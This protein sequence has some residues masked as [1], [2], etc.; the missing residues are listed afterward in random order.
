[1]LRNKK[2]NKNET[3]H[4]IICPADGLSAAFLHLLARFDAY[5]IPM[6]YAGNMD[7]KGLEL[8]DRLFVKFGK[9]FIPWRYT[10]EDYSFI[11][12]DSFE[13]LQEEKKNMALHN[14]TLASLL[15]HMRKV[16]KTASSMPLVP[17][18]IED[19]NANARGAVRGE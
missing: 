17:K 12:A 1:M 4:T 9:N 14:E 10:P 3:R 13:N 18:Y 15:S 19:I 16:G 5:D 2:Q 8:A 7:Y 6:Y 11:T